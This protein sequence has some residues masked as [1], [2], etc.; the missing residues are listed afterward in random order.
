M[1]CKKITQMQEVK[2]YCGNLNLS[3]FKNLRHA[4]PKLSGYFKLL[5]L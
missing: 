3:I 4:N 1:Y 5:K 2:K